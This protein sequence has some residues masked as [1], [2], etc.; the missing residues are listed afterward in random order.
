MAPSRT[1]NIESRWRAGRTVAPCLLALVMT[2]SLPALAATQSEEASPPPLAGESNAEAPC[3]DGR[4]RIRDLQHADSTIPD[5]L[6]RVYDVGLAWEAD[7]TLFALRLGCPLLETGYQWE[8][9]FFSKS[10]Q[11]FFSTDTIE[12]QATD[13][14]PNSIPILDTSEGMEV[15]FVYLSLVRAGFDEDA[16]LGA[17][18]GVTI[19]PSTDASPFGPPTAPKPEVYYHVSILQRGEV[20]DVW[21]AS[22]DGTIY[23]Y[24]SE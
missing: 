2:F 23:Q 20:V 10:A 21:V 18:G 22:R 15:L 9:T 7:A 19:R 14:D 6:A 16:L 11:A 24:N 17:G 8:G 3:F 4:L 13:D 12:T 1:R 5:G